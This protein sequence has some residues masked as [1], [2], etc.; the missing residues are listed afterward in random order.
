MFDTDAR[1]QALKE[2][3]K[4][5]ALEVIRLFRILPKAYEAQM[6][7]KQLIRSA[8]SV[9]ANYRAVCRARTRAVFISKLDIV[10]EEVDESAFWLELLTE[11]EAVR[12][13]EAFSLLAE[14]EELTRI[15]TTSRSTARKNR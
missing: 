7:G 15:F 2:R 5:F 14:A 13:Q 3:T 12:A 9:A 6:M 1:T 4:Q 10:V 8:A 11:S